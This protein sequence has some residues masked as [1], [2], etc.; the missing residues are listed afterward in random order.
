MRGENALGE[1]LFS[2]TGSR[3]QPHRYIANMF[4]QNAR[5]PGQEHGSLTNH[6]ALRECFQIV[7]SRARRAKQTV[8]LPGYIGCESSREDWPNILSIIREVFDK[9]PVSLEIVY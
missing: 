5:K 7:E 2:R 9:S 8:A 4:C 6:S 3:I 1:V